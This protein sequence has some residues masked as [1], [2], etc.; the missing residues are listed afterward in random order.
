MRENGEN[1]PEN[2]DLFLH[3]YATVAQCNKPGN[4]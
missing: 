4:H 2:S 3:I 1:M